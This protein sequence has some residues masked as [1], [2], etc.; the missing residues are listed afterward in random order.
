MSEKKS[1][2]KEALT[3]FNEIMEAANAKAKNDLANE[4]PEKF[5]NLLKEELDN[6]KKSKMKYQKISSIE[7]NVKLTEINNEPTMAAKN[8][9]TK[10]VNEGANENQPFNKPA[11]KFQNEEFNITEF[12]LGSASSAL[13]NADSEDE[14]ITMDEINNEI[15][16]M[17]TGTIAEELKGIDHTESPSV[18]DKS[19][20]NGKSYGK[21][22]SLRNQLDEMI[23]SMSDDNF[24]IKNLG[25]NTEEKIEEDTNN[26]IS[27]ED[28]NNVLNGE[29]ETEANEP[30]VDEAHGV[31]HTAQRT[32]ASTIPRNEYRSQS[33]LTRKRFD[34]QESKKKISGLI[35]EN[36]SLTKKLNEAKKNKDTVGVLLENYK[37]AIGKY[38]IHLKEMALFNTNLAYTNNLLV[39]EG[40][41][42]T[43]ED[44]VKI[45]NEFKNVNTIADS[46]NKYKE[47]LSEMTASKKT[48]SESIEN[49]TTVSVGVSSK[50]KLDEV[51]EKTAYSNNASIAK[52][53]KYINY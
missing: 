41:A 6:N 22:V 17:E 50:Q 27:D 21:L 11:P 53:K 38:R 37:T 25:Q 48:I 15:A 18:I 26:M 2:L 30:Q 42:L 10:K 4:F 16:A 20:Q 24:D 36:M 49:K 46:Q 32:V 1:I 31:S 12:D 44:K 47:F 29:D 39:N 40:L 9:T 19:V 52:M 51:V 7:D 13:D 33:E 23:G 34:M 3:D 8:V 28:I 45:I 35:K 5:N 43:Q 14:V